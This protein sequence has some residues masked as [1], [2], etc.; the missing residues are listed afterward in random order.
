MSPD[1]PLPNF[2]K[3]NM[4]IETYLLRANK[5]RIRCVDE[6]EAT[7]PSDGVAIPGATDGLLDAIKFLKNVDEAT[8]RQLII[9]T[10]LPIAGHIDEHHGPK[11]CGYRKLVETE[12]KTVGAPEA[13]SADDR[14]AWITQEHGEILTLLGDH[15]PT[16][17]V[18]NYR[19]GTTI[20]TKKATTDGQ[21]IFNFD[22]WAM[23]GY[24]EKLGIDPAAFTNHLQDVYRKTVT[25]L[26]GMTTFTEVR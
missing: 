16:A 9:S 5:K 17:A 8:A 22:I 10:K 12:H 4:Q 13:V 3:E 15:H 18:I 26:T 19:E 1:N 14:L 6:R 23:A 25:R 7:V 24:A 20:D 21:G 2:Q 11:G